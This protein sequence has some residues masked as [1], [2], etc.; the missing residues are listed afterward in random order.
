MGETSLT[1]ITLIVVQKSQYPE[2][3]AKNTPVAL[4]IVKSFARDMRIVNDQLTKITAAKT[5]PE[6]PEIIF[7]IAEFY[8]DAGH[9]DIA[10]YA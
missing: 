2:L 4:K 9:T 7:S 1:T 10:A 8:E 6:T 3:I 5:A